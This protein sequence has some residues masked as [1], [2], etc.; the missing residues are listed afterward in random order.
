MV[1]IQ[2]LLSD[3]QNREVLQ[4]LGGGLVVVAGGAWAVMKFF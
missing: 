2:A 3:P 4:W 1:D